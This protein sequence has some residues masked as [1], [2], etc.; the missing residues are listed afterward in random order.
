MKQMT[1]ILKSLIPD[2]ATSHLI[3]T[4]WKIPVFVFVIL[5]MSSSKLIGQGTIYGYIYSSYTRKPLVSASVV[6]H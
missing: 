6:I 3:R 1:K 5:I 2:N 4:G